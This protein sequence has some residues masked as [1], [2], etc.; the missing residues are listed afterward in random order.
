MPIL[1]LNWWS[2]RYNT[3][4][5]C[6]F[7]I[8]IDS[9]NSKSVEKWKR[10]KTQFWRWHFVFVFRNRLSFSSDVCCLVLRFSRR[11]KWNEFHVIK[12][13]SLLSSSSAVCVVCRVFQFIT[14]YNKCAQTK[15]IGS[16]DRSFNRFVSATRLKIAPLLRSTIKMMI[17]SSIAPS[18]NC[19]YFE[20]SELINEIEGWRLDQWWMPMIYFRPMIRNEIEN[21]KC[22]IG[23][24]HRFFVFVFL[25]FTIR[26]AANAES[27]KLR[28]ETHIL[29]KI[30][31]EVRTIIIIILGYRQSDEVRA[32][33]IGRLNG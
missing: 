3:V 25:T 23:I 22:F 13:K 27:H 32:S 6:L 16:F 4:T 33:S 18:I 10:K 26:N 8:C 12:S 24:S 5:H 9:I 7:T 2:P 14:N 1:N 21:N 31:C 15:W 17:K 19:Y 11:K 20:I 29:P 30:M 28:C